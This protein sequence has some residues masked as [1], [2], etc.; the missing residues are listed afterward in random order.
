LSSEDLEELETLSGFSAL[1]ITRL[2]KRFRRLDR[3]NKG[4][5]SRDELMS[6]PEL[7]M[8]PL[9]PRIV[10]MF[11]TRHE[12]LIDFRQFIELLA[13]FRVDTPRERKMKFAFQLYDI[14]DDGF[15]TAQ[16]LTEVLTLMVGRHLTPEQ[17]RQIVVKTIDQADLLDGDGKLSF[18]EFANVIGQTDIENKL[19]VSF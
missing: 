2:Y 16:D 18:E 14:D 9:A 1:H 15:I 4:S 17:I 19:A 12:E 13:V 7:A 5:I 8:N 10:S 6:I 3:D 11:D